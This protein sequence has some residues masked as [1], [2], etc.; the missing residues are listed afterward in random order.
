MSPLSARRRLW[1]WSIV[2]AMVAAAG[3]VWIGC[4]SRVQSEPA[5]PASGAASSAD[6][7]KTSIPYAEARPILEAFHDKLPAGLRSGTPAELEAAWPQWTHDHD[8]EV[9]ARLARGDED[10][11]VNF[12]MY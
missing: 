1:P 3:G 8:A 7:A 10:S 4:N 6:A 9:R 11:V 5:Q 2:A 12:W